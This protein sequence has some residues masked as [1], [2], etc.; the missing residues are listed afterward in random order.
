MMLFSVCVNMFRP[1]DQKCFVVAMNMR[2]NDHCAIN[3]K[4]FQIKEGRIIPSLLP[5]K[6]MYL[7]MI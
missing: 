7:F 4:D 5:A 1:I 3:G 6:K 2:F